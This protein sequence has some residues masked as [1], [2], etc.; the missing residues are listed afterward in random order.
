LRRLAD[1][2]HVERVTRGSWIATHPFQPLADHVISVETKRTDWRAGFWQAL[3]QA[4]DYTWLVVDLAGSA[5]T[6]ARADKFS[7]R[8]VGLAT[9]SVASEL[10]VI[11]PACSREPSS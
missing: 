2:G 9:L 11:V 8:K 10:K 4:A 1:Q 7:A 5:T 3:R 6:I